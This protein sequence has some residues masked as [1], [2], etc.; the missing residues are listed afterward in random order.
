LHLAVDSNVHLCTAQLLVREWQESLLEKDGQGRLPIHVALASEYEPML[1]VDALVGSCP[2]SLLERDGKG[3]LPMQVARDRVVQHGFVSPTRGDGW[4]VVSRLLKHCPESVRDIDAGGR[5]LLHHE[6]ALAT[7]DLPFI[8]FL[9]ATWSKALSVRGTSKDI[10][11][12]RSPPKG[13]C[14]WPWSTS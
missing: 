12:S 4:D 3:L 1:F 7:P 5:A 8:R 14:R 6:L 11:R 10:C 9:V 2:R 13:T